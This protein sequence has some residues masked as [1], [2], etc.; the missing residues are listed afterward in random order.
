M[1]VLVD[2][3]IW[4]WRGRRWAHLVSDRDLDELHALAH[5]I[6]MPYVAFQGDHYDVHEDLRDAAI[7]LGAVPTPGRDL[8]RALRA[9]GLRRRG[10]PTW[11]WTAR[12]DLSVLGPGEGVD[13]TRGLLATSQSR[14][15]GL[16]A[17]TRAAAVEAVA[18]LE[19]R[20]GLDEVGLAVRPGELLLIASVAVSLPPDRAA[21]LVGPPLE[22]VAATATIHRA[23]GERGTFVELA[24]DVDVPTP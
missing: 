24:V 4:P 9:A 2:E 7:A 23:T 16:D 8:V 5:A 21:A 6:G 3:A 22:R 17:D 19:S 13:V 1:T 11:A 12:H 20:T 10:T 18:R 15:A 14:E